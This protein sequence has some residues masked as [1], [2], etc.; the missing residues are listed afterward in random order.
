MPRIRTKKGSMMLFFYMIMLFFYM[1]QYRTWSCLYCVQLKT[2]ESLCES[3]SFSVCSISIPSK[4]GEE[5][6]HFNLTDLQA[7]Q[8]TPNG[9]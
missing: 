7:G 1:C 2:Q 4:Q 8:Q 6:K 5:K 3:L 9:C